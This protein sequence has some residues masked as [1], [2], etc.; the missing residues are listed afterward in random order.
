MSEQDAI[1]AIKSI[2]KLGNYLKKIKGGPFPTELLSTYGEL[3][4][5]LKLKELF[6]TSDIRFKRKAKADISLE[7]VNI[8]VKT[9]NLKQED[10]GKGYGF[11]LHVKKCKAHPNAFIE[12]PK[13]GKV[14][15]DFCY[16]D[17]LICVAVDENDF[18]NPLF[19]I[20]T[21]D[22]INGLTDKIQ[23]KSKRFWFS[24]YRILIPI[25]PDPKQKG[26]LYNDFDLSLATDKS[27]YKNR[28]DKIKIQ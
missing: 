24:P 25:D 20:F 12:H 21:R 8:E 19:Y 28:W 11:A 2:I 23:N 26:I 18:N 9:S 5:F 13:R 7:S 15:G 16:F 14:R 3:K 1:C 10:F 6:P 22:E 27:E 4:V 17:Y